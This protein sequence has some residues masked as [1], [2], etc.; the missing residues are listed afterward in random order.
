M[1]LNDRSW[2]VHTRTEERPPVAIRRGAQIIDSMLAD[3]CVIEEGAHVYCS[4]LSPGVY[5]G[6]NAVINESVVLTDSII[7]P[8]AVLNRAILDKRSRVC[9]GARVG[10]E[11]QDEEPALAMLGKS[12]VVPPEMVI[13]AGATVG[14]DVIAADF[15]A[16]EV[17]H[18]E[19]VQTRRLP[20]EI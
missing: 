2:I 4:V 12:S 16:N 14:T 15:T 18:G 1:D 3:G 10:E 13:K 17:S 20:N 8:G 6:K 7:E 9:T 19:Y 11:S 5:V